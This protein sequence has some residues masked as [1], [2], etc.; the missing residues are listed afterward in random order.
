MTE[1]KLPEMFDKLFQGGLSNNCQHIETFIQKSANDFMDEEICLTCGEI[2]RRGRN[3]REK[4][5]KDHPYE[6]I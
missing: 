1:E 4:S 2:I 6:R 5:S 3:L